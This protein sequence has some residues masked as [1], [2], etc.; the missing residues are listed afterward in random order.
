MNDDIV[1]PLPSSERSPEQ[2]Y[3][4]RSGKGHRF[5]GYRMGDHPSY[6]RTMTAQRQTHVADKTR[7]THETRA[8]A[9]YTKRGLCTVPSGYARSVLTQLSHVPFGLDSLHA[10]HAS[11]WWLCGAD[12]SAMDPAGRAASSR[13]NVETPVT[14]ADTLMIR[15]AF[16]EADPALMIQNSAVSEPRL[17]NL[18]SVWRTSSLVGWI[19]SRGLSS[20]S[21]FS[22]MIFSWQLYKVETREF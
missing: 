1:S 21:I 12:L 5:D 18:N 15:E 8:S 10:T 19:S 16:S 4:R 14:A 20:S 7:A 13:P 2:R 11:S 22:W 17:V 9:L 3:A 6:L